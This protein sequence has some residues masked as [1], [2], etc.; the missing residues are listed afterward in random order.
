MAFKM[1]GFPMNGDPEKKTGDPKEGKMVSVKEVAPDGRSFMAG[2]G[3]DYLAFGYGGDI[4]QMDSVMVHN[5]KVNVDWIE[6]KLAAT[7]TT[8]KK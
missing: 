5:N 8:P 6:A 2:D 3:N 7:D 4:S 1:K